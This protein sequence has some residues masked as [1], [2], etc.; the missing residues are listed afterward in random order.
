M[1]STFLVTFPANLLSYETTFKFSY[2]GCL[3]YSPQSNN[4]SSQI[5]IHKTFCLRFW[6]RLFCMVTRRK[7]NGPQPWQCPLGHCP[8]TWH[9]ICPC[10]LQLQFVL[11]DIWAHLVTQNYLVQYPVKL[12]TQWTGLNRSLFLWF[13][14]L[15]NFNTCHLRKIDWYWARFLSCSFSP[16]EI[17]MTNLICRLFP[18]HVPSPNNLNHWT[19]DTQSDTVRR[20]AG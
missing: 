13:L 11:Y 14:I 18:H 10:L 15:M 12:T 3:E 20:N 4:P 1:L 19:L 17:Q 7:Q 9:H 16:G 8:Y 2:E 6:I 5:Y